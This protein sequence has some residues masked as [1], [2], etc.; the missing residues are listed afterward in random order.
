MSTSLASLGMAL[1][2]WLDQLAAIDA[3]LRLRAALSRLDERTLRDVGLSRAE[4][5]A[6]VLRLP[7]FGRRGVSDPRKEPRRSM[8]SRPLPSDSDPA[9]R[10]PSPR[11]P[12]L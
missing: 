11:G 12:D 5:E 1:R 2:S 10:A 7:C 3:E 9:P 6:E 8:P 4:I